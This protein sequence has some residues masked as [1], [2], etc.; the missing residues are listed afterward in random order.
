MAAHES[1]DPSG[2]PAF[3]NPP[4]P[5]ISIRSIAT[6]RKSVD[7]KNMETTRADTPTS[8]VDNPTATNTTPA[9]DEEDNET[10]K[11]T[12][13]PEQMHSDLDKK[14]DTPI[15][16]QQTHPV[17][18]TTTTL[19][20]PS[21][22]HLA[23][24][25]SQ[26]VTPKASVSSASS[27]AGQRR[28]MDSIESITLSEQNEACEASTPEQE[29]EQSEDT[30]DTPR[31]RTSRRHLR[32]VSSLD[33][34]HNKWSAV[35]GNE[36]DGQN[37]STLFD[38]S[39][40]SPQLPMSAFQ[41][42]EHQGEAWTRQSTDLDAEDSQSW[43]R[44]STSTLDTIDLLEPGLDTPVTE[45]SRSSTDAIYRGSS[46]SS[47]EE[48]QV[49][50]SALDKTEEQ[51]KEDKSI[52]EGA[53]DE[54]TAFLLARLEQENAKFASDP[55]ASSS[56]K[57]A[58]ARA[59]AGS[60]PP[61][62]AHL[63]K[64]VAERDS[65]AIRH[66]LSADVQVPAELPPMTE[67]E[68][69]AALVQDYPSTAV[70]LPTLTT[71]KIRS[72]I[73]LPLRG[74]VWSSMAGAREKV[75]EDAF[76]KLVHEKSSYEGIINKDVGR[77]FPGVELFRDAEGEG[78]KM[79]GRV[80]KC[81]S[82]QDKDIG[83]CQGLGFL[84]GPL[85]MNMGEREAFCVLVRLMD[86]YSLRPSFLPSLSGLHMRIY[87]FSSLLQQHHSKLHNHLTELGIEPAYL[88]QWFLSCFAV[89]C[90]LPML[91]RIYDVIF[92]E[93][94]NE[95]VMRV[96]LALM[97]Q[98]EERMLAT[99][100]FE[101]VMQLLLGRELW[102]CYGGDAD[103]LVDDFTSLGDIVTFA[104]LSEL[105]KDFNNQSSETVGRSA[106]F[107]PDVQAAA[108]RFLGRIWAPGHNST[109]SKP[110]VPTHGVSPSVS[111]LSPQSA[112]K[113][114][115]PSAGISIF[116]RPTNFLRRSPSKQSIT[117]AADSSSSED[118]TSTAG[119]GA[120]SIASTAA[121]EMDARSAAMRE[122]IA[123]S[124]SLRSKPES[125]MPSHAREQQELN[126][127]IEDLLVAIS[128][129]QR[130]QSQLAA[131]LQREREDRSED[132]KA[133][134]ELISKL[135]KTDLEHRRKTMPPPQKKQD[136]DS[137]QKSRPNSVYTHAGKAKST[138][139]D[140]EISELVEK[141]QERLQVNVRFSANLE[142]K[143]QLRTTLA[144][145]REQL[146]AAE[147]QSRDLM[148]RLDAAEASM[149]LVQS[150]SEDLQAEIRELRLRVADD[151][152][153][154]QK[155]EYHLRELKA[156]ARTVE[157]NEL[158]SSQQAPTV[159]RNSNPA[160]GGL[161]EL[162]LGRRE[163]SS[164]VQSL[165]SLR[166]P[167]ALTTEFA[168]SAV[169]VGDSPWSGTPRTYSPPDAIAT[170]PSATEQPFGS[171]LPKERRGFSKRTS[172]LATQ[173]VFAT[174]E[175]ESV[176][177]EALLLELVNAKTSEAQARQEVDELRKALSVGKRQ[178]EAAMVQMRAEM[179]ALKVEAAK[180]NAAA[181]ACA[182]SGDAETTARPE[183][184]RMGSIF[185]LQ[186]T[187][188]SSANSDEGAGSGKTTPAAEDK[189]NGKKG[190]ATTETPPAAGGVGGWFWGRRTAS[191]SVN[192]A[193]PAAE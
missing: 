52:P 135:R 120:V 65:P 188:F 169:R 71:T 152:K 94:A 1:R 115:Q 36:I 83:Y 68:F 127:Q 100:E 193:T 31:V 57:G 133:M 4:S 116:G 124:A 125:I 128:E 179:E 160:P 187:P 158:Q 17:F 78:Q 99:T 63:K 170:P 145:T 122:S 21:L 51:E 76:D 157:R 166:S 41:V 148:A 112:E 123:D 159:N 64:L 113:E 146:V 104:R 62:M 177:E 180:A 186:S 93:G 108:G 178:Q 58:L 34:L 147:A 163:S 23:S 25:P 161:R 80:L 90:P 73:P 26:P 30:L 181:A 87:Q 33:I 107:L 175:H 14:L 27:K 20:D 29:A 121:T 89:T 136:V 77:S 11:P 56:K 9:V 45:T 16:D 144:R 131:M 134:K 162:R 97:R 139:S 191:Q 137:P 101:E 69:W 60:R 82:L 155:T 92:A 22:D 165:R 150:E 61:S 153:A 12:D 13:T 8:H 24:P 98:H 10:H 39:S 50:W 96:A 102:D 174:P 72:G 3:A 67:L 142:T 183:P 42:Q 53:E 15:V 151:F 44:P 141:M 91:F 185:S 109:P 190:S 54:S 40:D 70:R 129:T 111:S 114:V 105:E 48:L 192:T 81:F 19:H 7:G 164:S 28:S 172:S 6:D 85:L 103:A 118:S 117:M 171:A 74:V 79:L 38:T 173:E 49:D 156:Q 59:R 167:P 5:T 106:G 66:S 140:D 84:V 43:R 126:A 176:S 132:H 182:K 119:S 149:S 154:R 32:K 184:S 35:V 138:A 2:S 189:S 37:R 168:S 47:E 88:S 86:H 130:E 75:L 46:S 18:K 95:T 110:V 55:K 143:A